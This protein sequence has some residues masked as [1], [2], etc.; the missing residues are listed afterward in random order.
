MRRSWERSSSSNRMKTKDTLHIV[1]SDMHSGS[2]YALFLSREWHGINTSHIPRAGQIKIRQHWDYFCQEVKRVRKEKRLVVVHNGDAIDGDHHHSGDVCSVNPQEQADIHIEL[3]SEFQKRVNWQR[4]DEL[5]Y[6]R[7]TEVHTGA[8]FED[9]IARE[10]NAVPD[11]NFAAWNFLELN[12]NGVKS[13][14]TH[15]GGAVAMGA[16][17]GNSQKNALR[18]IQ[19]EAMK[20]GRIPPTVFYSGHVHTPT[21]QTHTYRVNG[22]EYRTMHYIITPSWQTKTRYAWMKAPIHKNKVG[23]VIHEIK[24]DGLVTI[25]RFL[26][27]DIEQ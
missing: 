10:L 18:N 16:N 11:G 14:F 8:D 1:L 3:M 9:Y 5:Y 24:A 2:N 19:I 21:Y 25:P 15:H 27:M 12:T 26:V 23:G 17:E 6:M 13:W 7:G 20:D 22:Y 4:G